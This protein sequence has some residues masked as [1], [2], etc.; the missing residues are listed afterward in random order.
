M[1]KYIQDNLIQKDMTKIK[2][3]KGF[4]TFEYFLKGY[5]TALIWSRVKFTEKKKKLVHERRIALRAKDMVKYANIIKSINDQDAVNMEKVIEEVF[6]KIGIT[7]KEFQ[8]S[9]DFHMNSTENV[10][11]VRFITDETLID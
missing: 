4:L 6:S 5:K 1:D 11:Y 3:D 10:K 2:D 8:K 9:I 7:E